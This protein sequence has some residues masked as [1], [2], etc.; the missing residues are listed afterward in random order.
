LLSHVE[1]YAAQLN[2]KVAQPVILISQLVTRRIDHRRVSGYA[3]KPASS[4]CPP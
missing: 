1:N 4:A 3:I 2:N